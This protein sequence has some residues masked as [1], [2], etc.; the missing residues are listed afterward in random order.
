MQV[1]GLVKQQIDSF[2]HFIERSMRDIVMAKD[3]CRITC[4][5]D[6]DWFLQYTDIHVG[7]PM[8]LINYIE[9]TLTPHDCRLRDMTYSA[10]ITVL[11]SLL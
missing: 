7:C 5:A 4:E 2:N 8:E 11:F 6:P 9:R 3:N 1:R 10:P